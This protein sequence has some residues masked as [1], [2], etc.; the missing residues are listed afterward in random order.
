MTGAIDAYFIGY[1]I[2]RFEALLVGHDLQSLSVQL[3]CLLLCTPDRAMSVGAARGGGQKPLANSLCP[4][5]VFPPSSVTLPSLAA[6]YGFRPGEKHPTL[7][8][9]YAEPSLV[10]AC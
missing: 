3:G 4:R 10:L 7:G 6:V 2:A 1:Y 9:A 5:P 8:G